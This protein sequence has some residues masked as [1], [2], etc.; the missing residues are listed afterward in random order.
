[1][2][3][4]AFILM[5]VLLLTVTS[6]FAQTDN[7]EAQRIIQ[8]RCAKCHSPELLTQA[9]ERG[10]NFDEIMTKMIRLGAQID[11]KEQQVLGIFWTEQQA[12]K[13][14]ESSAGETV[15]SDPLGEYR[16]VL[17][18]RCTG[19]H[20]LD[21]VEKAM[22]EGRSVDEL[23]TMMRQRGAVVTDQEKSVLDTFWGSPYKTE[24][25]K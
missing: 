15:A 1:M 11:S 9:M 12:P 14:E 17:E 5:T 24:L 13:S 20:S 10:E 25:P 7:T 18:N 19:C 4:N 22:M 8:E 6:A 2:H 16:S 23:V 21:I 3:R